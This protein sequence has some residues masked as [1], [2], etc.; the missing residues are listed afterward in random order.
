MEGAAYDTRSAPALVT[1]TD[2]AGLLGGWRVTLQTWSVLWWSRWLWSGN[3]ET[4][5]DEPQA[6]RGLLS[7]CPPLGFLNGTFQ[8]NC[9]NKDRTPEQVPAGSVRWGES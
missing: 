6:V 3:T 2:A 7:F 9:K 4:S 8:R 5:V 1:A